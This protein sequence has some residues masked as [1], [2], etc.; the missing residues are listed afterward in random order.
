MQR[1]IVTA[2]CVS[3]ND[4]VGLNEKPKRCAQ[5]RYEHVITVSSKYESLNIITQVDPKL[6]VSW[7]LEN[8]YRGTNWID[9]Y[10]DWTSIKMRKCGSPIFGNFKIKAG[11]QL[12][13][14]SFNSKVSPHEYEFKKIT[15]KFPDRV[16]FAFDIY[17]EIDKPRLVFENFRSLTEDY[18]KLLENKESCDVTF[19]IGDEEIPAHKLI[20]A[21]RS[22]VFAK[23]FSSDMVEKNTGRVEIDDIEPSTF[24]LFLRFVYCGKLDSE[25]TDELF[26]LIEAANKYSIK[27]LVHLCAHRISYNIPLDN[28]ID[29][30]IVADRVGADFLKKDC[31]KMIAA[32]RHYPAIREGY[33]KLR[34]FHSDL[35]L[36]L[37]DSI[38]GEC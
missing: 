13:V 27:D 32:C 7:I 31:V 11:D 12:A 29:I 38:M 9:K 35:A 23:M 6:D 33:K 4:Y 30:L 1:Q 24:K 36:Q 10:M 18:E 37:C 21:G 5:F 26:K 14:G 20:V 19:V 16:V 22:N 3:K 15:I 28:A 8:R 17:R 25:D 34:K 2:D